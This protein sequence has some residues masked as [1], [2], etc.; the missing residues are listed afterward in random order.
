MK[1]PTKQILSLCLL[2]VFLVS[3]GMLLKQYLD[4]RLGDQVYG[5]AQALAGMD[6]P[7]QGEG[8]PEEEGPA[9]STEGLPE[10]LLHLDL[11][12]MRA[13]SAD[14]LGWITIPDSVIS[15]PLVQGEDNDYYLNHT[16]DGQR[17]SVGAI[18]LEETSSPDFSDF[19]TLIYGHRMG[20]GSMFNSLHDFQDQAYWQAHP[21][22]YIASEDGLRRYAVFAAYEASIDSLTYQIGFPDTES[23]ETFLAHCLDSNVIT[24]GLTPTAEDQILTLSTC[25]GRGHATRWVVQAI[26]DGRIPA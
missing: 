3:G 7:A 12:A 8:A 16:W 18:F 10:G 1:K 24:T 25:T 26:L 14:A 23:R 9:F 6:T 21:Y 17:S 4:Y 15:Y 2:A 13:V 20:N 22:I 19:H 5:Q 11:A